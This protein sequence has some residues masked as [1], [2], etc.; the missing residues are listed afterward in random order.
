MK[1]YH[2]IYGSLLSFVLIGCVP[3][4]APH[5]KIILHEEAR[6]V[7]LSEGTMVNCRILGQVEGKDEQSGYPW[8]EYNQLDENAKNDLRNNAAV[9]N[10]DNKLANVRI[11]SKEIHCQLPRIGWTNCSR[12][13]VENDPYILVKYVKYKG[14]I[15]DCGER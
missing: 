13:Y 12:S 8:V 6:K 10:R 5:P 7:L 14:E 3:P 15:L 1:S 9:L 11:L 4:P 2:L